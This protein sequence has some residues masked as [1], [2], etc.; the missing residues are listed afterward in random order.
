MGR[1]GVWM[2]S[3]AGLVL[4]G[5]LQ[6]ATAQGLILTLPKQDGA[7]VRF[8]GTV[9]QVEFRPD[10]AE[11]DI[12]ME[13][14]QQ[15]TVKSVGTETAAFRGKQVPC[16]WIEIKV[17]TGK[18]SESGIEAG[19][20]G[21]RI[22]KVLVPEE[23]V[24]GQ[25]ADGGKIPFSFLDVIKGFRKTGGQVSPLPAGALQVFPLVAPVMHYEAVE[26][27][28][29]DSEDISLPGAP[30]PIKTQ[31]FKAKRSIESD[32][33]RST[34]EAELWRSDGTTI[35]FGLVKWTVKTL[36]ERKDSTQPRQ[37]YKALT[38]TNVE[39]TAHEWGTGAKSELVTN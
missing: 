31:K 4:L 6:S 13:W 18:P 15:L 10:A 35:P 38:Q 23:R 25:L 32:T 24:V 36:L 8:E 37:S 14:I 5:S 30:A 17:V 3:L 26:V 7:W 21:E 20:V 2:L 11:G 33:E 22:Y 34:N 9:K 1:N 29:N 19:P 12:T 27:N 39:M 28:G 16:R